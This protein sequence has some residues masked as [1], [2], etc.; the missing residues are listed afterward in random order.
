MHGCGGSVAKIRLGGTAEYGQTAVT[1]D[2]EE[3]AWIDLTKLGS[4]FSHEGSN[5]YL[6]LWQLGQ[7]RCCLTDCQH[8]CNIPVNG[9]RTRPKHFSTYI[10]LYT[11]HYNGHF[12]R[13]HGLADCRF[14]IS[15]SGTIFLQDQYPLLHQ[16]YTH[17]FHHFCIRYDS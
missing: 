14:E 1:E 10:C 12:P 3:E 6:R 5:L 8:D 2:V 15:G 4:V 17:W 11:C 9:C 7:F 13:K 16:N